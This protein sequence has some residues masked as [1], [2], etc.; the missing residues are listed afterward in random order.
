MSAVSAVFA[1]ACSSVSRI[2]TTRVVDRAHQHDQHGQQRGDREHDDEPADDRAPPQV[3][4]RVG[5]CK[6]ALASSAPQPGAAALEAGDDHAGG[7]VR[8]VQLR[9]CRGVVDRFDQ[10]VV[11]LVRLLPDRVARASGSA[12]RGR[13]PRARRRWRS[14]SRRSSRCSTLPRTFIAHL[15][16]IDSQKSR[17]GLRFALTDGSTVGHG[18]GLLRR[19]PRPRRRRRRASCAPPSG[20]R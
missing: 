7:F 10:A 9:E 3:L 16:Q 6:T 2:A 18:A 12:R 4:L 11:D 19:R 1:A 14:C 20:G 13:R 17:T 5:E 8:R 15:P